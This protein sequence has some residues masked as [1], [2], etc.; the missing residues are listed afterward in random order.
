MISSAGGLFEAALTGS[1]FNSRSRPVGDRL[2]R[3]F[4]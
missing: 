3:K 2:A 1:Y 4:Q